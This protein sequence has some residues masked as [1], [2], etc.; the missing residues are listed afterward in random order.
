MIKKRLL[1][2]AVAAVLGVYA[3]NAVAQEGQGCYAQTVE[4][5]TPGTLKNSANPVPADRQHADRALGVPQ[6]DNTENFV[7]LGYGG[8]LTLG[9]GGAVMDGVGKDL[10]VVETSYASNDCLSDGI[11]RAQVYLSQNGTD[12]V[13]AGELCRDGSVDIAAAGF[14]WASYIKIENDATSTTPDGFDVDGVYAVNGCGNIPAP[15]CYAV[16]VMDFFQGTKENGQPITDPMRTDETKALGEPENDRSSG[17]DNFFTL[18]NG[19]W[20]E[21]R[22]SDFIIQDGTSAPDLRVYETTWGNLSCASYPE[23]AEISVSANNVNWYSLGFHCQSSDISLDLDAVVPG[24]VH[25]KYVRI[26]TNSALGSTEDFFDVDGVEALFG[27]EPFE[28]ETPNGCFAACTTGEGYVQGTTKLGG[29]LPA[30]RTHVD[31]ALGTPQYSDA[32]TSPANNN[33]LTLGYGGSLT[34]CFDGFIMNDAGDDIEIVETSFNNPSCASYPEYADIWVSN[35]NVNW[36]FVKTG[37]HNFTV[38]FDDAVDASN[39]PIY[40]PYVQYVKIANNDNLTTTPDAYDVDGV[41][42]IASQCEN[43]QGP[44]T[45][46]PVGQPQPVVGLRSYPNPSRGIVNFNFSSMYTGNAS[47]E[48]FNIAGQRVALLFNDEVKENE[49]NVVTFDMSQLPNGVYISKLST[50]EGVVTGKVML[51]R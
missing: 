41:R 11:E 3:P 34:L 43:T 48:V 29:A 37:C 30:A 4:N 5:Y 45:N 20:I 24:G 8:S 51:A 6:N 31:R 42:L 40:L 2:G 33:F 50:S 14:T 27:C 49:E 21:L 44:V 16:E 17:A 25:V 46:E 7:S 28:P 26:A 35:D 12:F 19:G 9:F 22:M 39:N 47:L 13:W 1:T 36:Y 23:Y 38:N 10:Y 32:T 15:G 18:G